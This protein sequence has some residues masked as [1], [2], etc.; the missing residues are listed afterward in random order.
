MEKWARTWEFLA[1]DCSWYSRRFFWLFVSKPPEFLEQ[2]R[3]ILDQISE[4][5]RLMHPEIVHERVLPLA[6]NCFSESDMTT[7]HHW[8]ENVCEEY[9]ERLSEGDAYMAAIFLG[10]KYAY[11]VDDADLRQLLC[12]MRLRW[13]QL[14]DSLVLDLDV[15]MPPL[16]RN[17]WQRKRLKKR[18]AWTFGLKDLVVFM[19]GLTY[20]NTFAELVNEA[21]PQLT[22]DQV[23][24]L[25]RLH[26]LVLQKA[27]GSYDRPVL[28]WPQLVEKHRHFLDLIPKEQ[29]LSS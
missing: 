15:S 17:K 26:P 13:I 20:A 2:L 22:D 12:D 3:A 29:G 8:V 11:M 19:R 27:Y 25:T 6:T 23:N 14:T 18:A 21:L 4:H 28:T 5:D 16:L 1:L 24:E 10:S 9:S 7:L